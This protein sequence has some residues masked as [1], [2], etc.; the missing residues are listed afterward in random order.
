MTGVQTCALPISLEPDYELNIF[1]C[2]TG[3]MYLLMMTRY[4][5]RPYM[6]IC[7]IFDE[8]KIFNLPELDRNLLYAVIVS[9]NAE[10][11]PNTKILYL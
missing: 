9:L 11:T 8:E 7:L 1:D 3:G 4:L 6:K 5:L 10:L 2:L